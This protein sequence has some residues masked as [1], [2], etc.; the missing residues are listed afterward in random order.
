MN[1]KS[2]L[3]IAF[4]PFLMFAQ[5]EEVVVEKQKKAGFI[6]VGVSHPIQ[7]GENAAAEAYNFSVGFYASGFL[8]I[9]P[10]FLV[11]SIFNYTTFKVDE[12]ANVGFFT[13]GFVKRYLFGAGYEL[14]NKN[15][16]LFM[17]TAGMGYVNY[18]NKTQG[19]NFQDTGT[20]F[21]VS[22][23]ISKVFLKELQVFAELTFAYDDIRTET[24]PEIQSFFNN[25]TLLTPAIGVR[26]YFN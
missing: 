16:F 22:S 26:Y 3:F 1:I 10:R 23:S 15:D 4:M 8:Y 9:K 21:Y 7:F 17:S 20:S 5:T 24:P 6:Q 12:N 11:G 2:F 19:E 18:R 25:A 14:I 13:D